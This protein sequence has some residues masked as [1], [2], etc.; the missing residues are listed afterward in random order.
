MLE[1]MASLFVEYPS[2]SMRD[3]PSNAS[4]RCQTLLHAYSL[5]MREDP[6]YLSPFDKEDLCMILFKAL[7]KCTPEGIDYL[8]YLYRGRMSRI[9]HYRVIALFNQ[10]KANSS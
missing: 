9:Q 4:L 7:V 6:S 2:I 8:S 3:P 5:V 1:D 10:A